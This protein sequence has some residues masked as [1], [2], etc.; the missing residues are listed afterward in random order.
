[1]TTPTPHNESVE[2]FVARSLAWLPK[3][4]ALRSEVEDLTHDDF[5]L[6]AREKSNQRKLWDAGLAGICYPAE[7]GGLGYPVEYQQAFNDIA[8]DFD[9]PLRLNSGTLCVTLP[10]VL[11]EGT[12]EQKQQHIRA[13]LKGEEYMS[14][15]LSEPGGGSDLASVRTRADREGDGWRI[16]GSKIWSSSAHIS[17][18][19][20]LLART[21][22][23]AVK[24]AG[25]TFFLVKINQP[26]IT[27]N[28]ITTIN[29]NSKFCE[30][31]FDNVLL[32]DGDVLGAVGEGWAAV[33]AQLAHERQAVGGGSPYANGVGPNK[34]ARPELTLAE[35]ASLLGVTSD[36][37]VREILTEA[38][39]AEAVHAQLV[40]RIASA[41]KN[42]L[43]P[44]SAATIIR[45]NQA[46]TIWQG[47]ESG[48][49]IAGRAALSVGTA[50]SGPARFAHEYMMQQ[51]MGIAGGTVE[52]SRNVMTERL[53]G[54]PR[55]A[56]A[57]RGIPFSE[58][59][60]GRSTS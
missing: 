23:N 4:I 25:L 53:L 20:F 11:T 9:I 2:E 37:A 47:S 36:P 26:G 27:V 18:Y 28:R 49:K 33:S 10:T 31:F 30:V 29:G 48:M 46:L 34:T 40:D 51:A 13:V 56:S 15:F 3:N 50:K 8:Q 45:V 16:N 1:M 22:W 44:T 24:H 39:V 59:K 41:I 35:L 57:D 14:Q 38:Y 58:V 32:S 5:Q 52:M 60:S 6:I 19:G 12:E 55:E 21:D 7:Y 42:D 17:D 54:M 43:L